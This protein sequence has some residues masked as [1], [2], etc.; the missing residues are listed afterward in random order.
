MWADE[1]IPPRAS[2]GKELVTISTFRPPLAVI[3]LNSVNSSSG[4][5]ST[6]KEA[7][8]AGD[9]GPVVGTPVAAS[10]R[11]RT[12]LET[13]ASVKG[14][15]AASVAAVLPTRRTA[16]AIQSH[17][18]RPQATVAPPLTIT[19]HSLAEYEMVPSTRCA[20]PLLHKPIT[21]PHHSEE[22]QTTSKVG[23]P[24]ETASSLSA[25]NIAGVSG[26]S[27]GRP[28]VRRGGGS[29]DRPQGVMGPRPPAM[30]TTVALMTLVD[31]EADPCCPTTVVHIPVPPTV[32]TLRAALPSFRPAL[33]VMQRNQP[34]QP[35]V[36]GRI[37]KAHPLIRAAPFAVL[38]ITPPTQSLVAQ[39]YHPIRPA[40]S[41][42]ESRQGTSTVAA[43]RSV[44]Q[45]TS[46]V[47]APRSVEQL[48]SY[49]PLSLHTQTA[50]PLDACT[51][52]PTP[53]KTLG[54]HAEIAKEESVATQT[55]WPCDV[56]VQCPSDSFCYEDAAAVEDHDVSFT[57][58]FR[59]C[60][61]MEALAET[62]T[63]P[64]PT[65]PAAIDACWTHS[66]A[67]TSPQL[68]NGR[69]EPVISTPD[70]VDKLLSNC[71]GDGGG[72]VFCDPSMSRHRWIQNWL[73]KAR[74]SAVDHLPGQL[75]TSRSTAVSTPMLMTVTPETLYLAALVAP[76]MRPAG[77]GMR[78]SA[79]IAALDCDGQGE[80][81]FHNTSQAPLSIAVAT[82]NACLYVSTSLAL[83]R[84]G[85]S[86]TIAVLSRRE[87]GSGGDDADG[88]ADLAAAPAGIAL[89]AG[90]VTAK[91]VVGGTTRQECVVD[92]RYGARCS[93]AKDLSEAPPL[94]D[95]FATR[96]PSEA[97]AATSENSCMMFPSS[98]HSV[99][100]IHT[101]NRRQVSL[102]FRKQAV[103][104]GSVA[105]GSL[106]RVKVELCNPNDEEVTVTFTDPALPFVLA[107][108]EVRMRP[109]AYVRLPVRFVPTVGDKEYLSELVA[110]TIVAGSPAPQVCTVALLGCTLQRADI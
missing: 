20:V 50:W 21:Q 69:P 19:R 45:G 32:P 85:E 13:V 53:E 74:E 42:D 82:S 95:V 52:F 8:G 58:T 6:W 88:Q 80:L 1:N 26:V 101:H 59:D 77:G 51:Q 63:S 40:A 14:E 75:S 61:G 107:H 16:A 10:K 9:D 104:F 31:S 17:P 99:R 100:S 35:P 56:S 87:A 108:S 94:F 30:H 67:Q 33:A 66:S 97:R 55:L 23:H 70:L 36:E 18:D 22:V 103:N 54:R 7:S 81:V 90:Y 93:K 91:A 43:P 79:S 73:A 60:Q 71:L 2:M 68:E 96:A 34:S 28:G 25:L 105:T 5:R 46:P 64:A 29:S 12:P 27:L 41:E 3:G 24:E 38:K 11:S 49:R 4:R 37:T 39:V 44:E 109:K 76:P 62:L 106:N 65:D 98:A 48:G 89:H 102:F 92:V 47:A 84:A 86:L 15:A 72:P 83:V 57:I 78:S 110:H